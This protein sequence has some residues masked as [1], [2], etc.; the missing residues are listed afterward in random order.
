MYNSSVSIEPNGTIQHIEI[1]SYPNNFTGYG[2]DLGGRK[3]T[4]LLLYLKQRFGEVN[5]FSGSFRADRWELNI[6]RSTGL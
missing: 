4:R 5:S 6:N 3:L 1:L 2:S